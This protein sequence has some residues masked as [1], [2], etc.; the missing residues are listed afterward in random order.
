MGLSSL[1]LILYVVFKG[2]KV[3]FIKVI[4]QLDEYVNLSSLP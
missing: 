2:W 4:N 3:E 1:I